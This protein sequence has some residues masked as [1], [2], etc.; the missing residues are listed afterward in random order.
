MTVH[1]LRLKP[2]SFLL[3]MPVL[4]IL[5]CRKLHEWQVRLDM[6]LKVK[7]ERAGDQVCE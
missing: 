1:Y 7:D 6:F 4:D 2:A 3:S 5:S